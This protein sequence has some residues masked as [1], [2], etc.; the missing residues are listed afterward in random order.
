LKLDKL[1]K[2]S[3]LVERLDKLDPDNASE[4]K[5]DGIRFWKGKKIIT[6]AEWKKKIAKSDKAYQRGIGDQ[7]IKES[8]QYFPDDYEKSL[9]HLVVPEELMEVVKKWHNQYL[10]LMQFRNN[11]RCGRSLCFNCLL[12]PD[13]ENSGKYVG[14][15]RLVARAIEDDNQEEEEEDSNS[16]TST[17]THSLYPCSVLNRFNC[18]YDRKEETKRKNNSKPQQQERNDDADDEELNSSDV[19]YLFLLSAYSFRAESAFIKARKE[20]STV[21]PIKSVEDIYHAL[22]NRETR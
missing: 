5:N 15:S 2:D 8:F 20:K 14:I 4:S 18:P 9:F 21:V 11:P 19:D 3:K 10:E 12:C 1:I 6:L 17:T 13:K 22:T 16:N 7:N